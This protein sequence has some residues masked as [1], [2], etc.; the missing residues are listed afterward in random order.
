MSWYPGSMQDIY[1]YMINSICLQ[2][3]VPCNRDVCLC[4]SED[5]DDSDDICVCGIYC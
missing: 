3:P 2:R 4:G 5:G 1:E